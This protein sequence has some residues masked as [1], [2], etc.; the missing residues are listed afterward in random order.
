MR[1][2]PIVHVA[3][4][5]PQL[6]AEHARAYAELVLA[7]ARQA[8]LSLVLHVTLY[9]GAG[10]LALL[11]TLFAGVALLLY[12]AGSG[13]PRHAWLL[14]A[15]PTI[16]LAVAIL[17]LTVAR[18]LPVDLTLATVERQVKEDIAMLHEATLP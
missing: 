15:V 10:V 16:P 2:H 13:E 11:G 5:Q 6:L 8:V 4:R 3:A 9:A 12:G 1:L 18:T 17:C 14:I 7:E